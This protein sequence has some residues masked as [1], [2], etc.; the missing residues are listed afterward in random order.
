MTS[1]EPKN[2]KPLTKEAELAQYNA[3]LIKSL[4]LEVDALRNQL[5]VLIDVIARVNG[6]IVALEG[7]A[8]SQNDDEL[9]M[10]FRSM[11]PKQ[12]AA[13]QMI[14]RGARN[15][16]IAKRFKVT[17]STAKVYVAGIMRHVGAS[18]RSEIVSKI[19]RAFDNANTKDYQGVAGIPHDWDLTWPKHKGHAVLE[20]RKHAKSS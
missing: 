13:L 12:N 20:R 8:Q 18:T 9:L 4:R 3:D 15:Q 16:E 14:L 11:S 2:K 10:P 6:P 19:K 7:Q 17:E 5:G 1:L